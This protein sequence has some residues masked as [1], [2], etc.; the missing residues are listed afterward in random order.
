VSAFPAGVAWVD[1]NSVVLSGSDLTAA[2]GSVAN[3]TP[4]RTNTNAEFA[5]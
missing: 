5:F 4:V 2:Y 3:W 1:E